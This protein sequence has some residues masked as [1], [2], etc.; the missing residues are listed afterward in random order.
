[1]SSNTPPP[2]DLHAEIVNTTQR[3]F[4]L[5]P[6]KW[7]IQIIRHLVLSHRSYNNTHMVVVRPTGGDKSLVYQVARYLMKGIT[8]FISPL[9]PLASGQTQ[10]LRM[11]TRNRPEFLS[12]LMT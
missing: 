12:L 7:Q 6:R 11:I 2:D 8:L 1:M 5:H 9:L 10:K 3:L 4:Q